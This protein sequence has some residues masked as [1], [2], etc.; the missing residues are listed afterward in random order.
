MPGTVAVPGTSP[1]P[2][3]VRPSERLAGE[4]IESPGGSA[5]LL[6]LP[7]PAL[8]RNPLGSHERG[9]ERGLAPSSCGRPRSMVRWAR[10]AQNADDKHPSNE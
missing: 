6:R 3:W 2:N 5:R 10:S 9:H 1:N 8:D 7:H 4:K